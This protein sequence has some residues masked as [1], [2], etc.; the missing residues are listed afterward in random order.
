MDP[1]KLCVKRSKDERKRQDNNEGEEEEDEDQEGLL[2]FR[3]SQEAEH[4]KQASSPIHSQRQGNASIGP[5]EREAFKLREK[6]TALENQVV[7]EQNEKDRLREHLLQAQREL[8][9]SQ[10]NLKEAED[11]LGAIRE[12][13]A[14]NEKALADQKEKL[15]A[16]HLDQKVGARKSRQRF[17]AAIDFMKGLLV[18]TKFETLVQTLKSRLRMIVGAERAEIYVVDRQREEL[19]AYRERTGA[20]RPQ[21]NGSNLWMGR[22]PMDTGIVGSVI[23]DKTMQVVQEVE[24]DVRFD[25]LVDGIGS[26]GVR[27]LVVYPI[28]M[29]QEVVAT[30]VVVNKLSPNGRVA[31]DTF[32]TQD[33]S[34][35]QDFAT[36]TT[37]VFLQ[38][39]I[40]KTRSASSA[41]LR[42][43]NAN[44]SDAEEESDDDSHR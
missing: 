42:Q 39:Q 5:A 11:S 1:V 35:V 21:P 22:F 15:K 40:G 44:A 6:L 28:L 18:E 7:R 14:S 20:R 32:T 8:H 38:Q 23:L 43:L 25:A 17:D 4:T 24:K 31:G 37:L 3:H 29:R 2:D 36:L 9:I 26:N 30:V 12:R 41:S 33:I 34:A 19:I 13:V 27:S 16:A 10:T